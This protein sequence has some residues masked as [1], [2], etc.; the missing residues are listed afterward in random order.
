MLVD[1]TRGSKGGVKPSAVPRLPGGAG[2]YDERSE[3]LWTAVLRVQRSELSAQPLR[4]AVWRR[5]GPTTVDRAILFGCGGGGGTGG[6]SAGAAAGESSLRMAGVLQLLVRTV[7]YMMASGRTFLP[8]GVVYTSVA[9]EGVVFEVLVR[10]PLLYQRLL[11]WWNSAVARGSPAARGLSRAQYCWFV[12]RL[13][14]VL[15]PFVRAP[16]PYADAAAV[17]EKDWRRDHV[18][19]AC[20]QIKDF[21]LSLFH[22]ASV[23]VPSANP[24]NGGF[25]A[26]PRKCAFLD[27]L[28]PLVF[29]ADAAD[30]AAASSEGNSLP[31]LRAFEG[32]GCGSGAATSFFEAISLREAVDPQQEATGDGAAAGCSR[33]LLSFYAGSRTEGSVSCAALLQALPRPATGWQRPKDDVAAAATLPRRAATP[34]AATPGLVLPR[35]IAQDVEAMGKLVK[36]QIR[37]TP[38]RQEGSAVEGVIQRRNGSGSAGAGGGRLPAQLQQRPALSL[39]G[40]LLLLSHT[41]GDG[42][43]TSP[44]PPPV[45]RRQIA[46]QTPPPPPL[47]VESA[48]DAGAVVRRCATTTPPAFAMRGKGLTTPAASSSSAAATA[49]AA[50]PHPQQAQ[51]S[52]FSLPAA[53]QAAVE[54]QQHQ[55]QRRRRRRRRSSPPLP[56]PS[57]MFQHRVRRQGGALRVWAEHQR[58]WVEAA[59]AAATPLEVVA[60]TRLRPVGGEEGGGRVRTRTCRLRWPP[61]LEALWGHFPEVVTGAT[62]HEVVLPCEGTRLPVHN[63][64]MLAELYKANE[65]RSLPLEV[66]PVVGMDVDS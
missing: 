36:P 3:P 4:D 61:R 10:N 2:D 53:V 16:A 43:S 13:L 39:C 6:T 59:A 7:K 23:F 47:P 62:P 57:R 27:E 31:S 21:V 29:G 32:D 52:G 14:Y 19:G 24:S 25:D 9:D 40:E 49:T 42:V 45:P 65:Y 17:A 15:C 30:A 63:D 11:R 12:E 44:P 34:A 26:L 55:Q 20:V 8:D 28:H 37:R 54:K 56:P 18:K 50:A 41:A 66:V 60:K 33:E 35:R 64:E 1:H 51:L 38:P 48:A 22:V 5:C 46:Q 58:E